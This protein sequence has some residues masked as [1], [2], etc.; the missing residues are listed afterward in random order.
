M[1]TKVLLCAAALAASL[2]SS[3]AQNVY[4]LNV[5]GYVNVT[6]PAGK[7]TCVAN[8]L[9]ASMGGTIA[10]GN[11]M[12][13]LFNINTSVNLANGSKFQQ[14]IPA[15]NDY[16]AIIN[17]SSGTKKWGSNFSM[18]P[19]TAA[20]FYNNGASDTVVTFTGQVPQGSYNVTTFASGKFAFG[21]SPV[22]I[23]GDVTNSTTASW[24]NG[25][26]VSKIGL[27][28]ANGD[29][30]ATF[31]SAVNDWNAVTKWSTGTKKWSSAASSTVGVGQGFMYYNNGA[32]ANNWVSSFT[33]F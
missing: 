29:T 2:A 18:P 12:T 20:M 21:G 24:T 10:T 22:P 19:G 4:S 6:L 30:I 33:V 26:V 7:Y 8:P 25:T 17:Y 15:A 23:G 27:V 31:N 16:G 1:R 11:D 9:D 13:N 3:M 5:V 32:S 14:F 28:P